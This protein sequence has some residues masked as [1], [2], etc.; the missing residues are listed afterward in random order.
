MKLEKQERV[1]A[2]MLSEL[3]QQRSSVKQREEDLREVAKEQRDTGLDLIDREKAAGRKDDML[4]EREAVCKAGAI[5]VAEEDRR[6]RQIEREALAAAEAARVQEQNARS[7]E[8]EVERREDAV[9]RVEE[10]AQHQM[11]R[12]R[13]A[14]TRFFTERH[15]REA[16]Q[17]REPAVSAPVRRGGAVVLEDECAPCGPAARTLRPALSARDGNAAERQ[18]RQP[19]IAERRHASAQSPAADVP[20]SPVGGAGSA[21]SGGDDFGTLRKRLQAFGLGTSVVEW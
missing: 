9:R 15:E 16:D 11:R 20:Q 7:N 21:S 2:K 8:S 19:E 13:S 14:E 6:V 18:R 4:R 1:A 12:L 3:E 17:Q 10:Q 5:K